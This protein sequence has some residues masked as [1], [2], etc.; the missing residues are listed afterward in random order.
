MTVMSIPP[1]LRFQHR[2]A[3]VALVPGTVQLP[4][5]QSCRCQLLAALGCFW[6]PGHVTCELPPA[7]L[8]HSLLWS[9]VPS[10]SEKPSVCWEEQNALA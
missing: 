3:G 6:V 5:A 8:L 9:L 2:F 7:S 1:G 10:T 4:E